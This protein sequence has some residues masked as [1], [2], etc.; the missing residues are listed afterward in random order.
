MKAALLKFFRRVK[1]TVRFNKRLTAF[2][3]CIFI[4]GLFWFLNALT[5]NYNTVLSFPVAYQ[6][7]PEN[8]VLTR[9]LPQNISL[10][11]NAEGYHLLSHQ[12]KFN[13]DTIYIDVS[14][15]NIRAN[16]KIYEAKMPTVTRFDKIASQLS[17][18]IKI[19]RIVPDTIYFS[20]GNKKSKNVP[21]KINAS[22]TFE[23]QYRLKDKISYKPAS[24]QVEGLDRLVDSIKV[25]ET[26]SLILNQLNKS[27][28]GQ[29]SI[30]LPDQYK[31]LVLSSNHVMVNVPVEQYTEASMEVPIEVINLPGNLTLKI[32]P[33]KVKITY[34]VAFSDFDR[35]LED[36]FKAIVDYG[37]LNNTNRLN[38]EIRQ[39]PGFVTVAKITPSKVEYIIQKK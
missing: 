9:K 8:M 15:L 23:K 16:G 13:R 10:L 1:I 7:L 36:H 39:L 28:S 31:S 29:L 32:F 24:I 17:P 12:L 20:F 21:V 11:L 14:N 5:K 25:L 34:W 18:E 6:N 4:A 37:K 2:L 35:V 33:E 30:Q 22:I 38:V 3:I 26:D 27:V 19:T